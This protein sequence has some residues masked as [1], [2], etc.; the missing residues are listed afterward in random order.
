[1]IQKFIQ[2]FGTSLAVAIEGDNEQEINEA[3]YSFWNYG[4]TAA[5]L[6][7]L[8]DAR[9]GYFWTTPERLMRSLINASRM[10]ILRK[11]DERA[12]TGQDKFQFKGRKG[13]VEKL[14]REEAQRRLKEFKSDSFVIPE[15]GMQ[16][17]YNVSIE[18]VK[19]EV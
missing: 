6:I 17:H 5:D 18:P 16:Y 14:A 19:E 10:S 7:W 1:M 13:G 3:Y 4:A 9:F 2:N 11:E 15:I 8:V 12:E